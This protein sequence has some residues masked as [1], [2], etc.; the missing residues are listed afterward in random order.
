MHAALGTIK[1]QQMDK[2]HEERRWTRSSDKKKADRGLERVP[3]YADNPGRSK[4][5]CREA[6]IQGSNFGV[7]GS[8]GSE[9]REAF[10]GIKD[11]E[12]FGHQGTG[13]G[14]ERRNSQSSSALLCIGT[15]EVTKTYM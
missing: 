13:I 12:E 11:R 7:G 4:G 6:Y 14:R 8:Q 15:S 10:R 5:K 2:E 1:C 9:V 3:G